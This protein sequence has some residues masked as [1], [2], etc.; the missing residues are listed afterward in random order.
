MMNL[1]K[2]IQ[3]LVERFLGIRIS[4]YPFEV[5]QIIPNKKREDAWFSYHAIFQSII[6][7]YQVDLVLDVG[8]NKGQFVREL[9]GFYPGTV[10]SFEPVPRTFAALQ[11]ARPQDNN[12]FKLNYALGSKSE[13]QYINT[14]KKDELNS[15]LETNDNFVTRFGPAAAISQKEPIKVRR[16][17]DVLDEIPFDINNRKILLKMD[18]QGYDLEVFHGARKILGNIVAL[19]SEISQLPVYQHTPRWTDTVNEYEKAGF[20]LAGLYPASRDG[21]RYIICDC[22]MVKRPDPPAVK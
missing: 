6:E 12:W 14:F 19:Q 10:V 16:L 13:D 17:D 18:T 11:M 4:G 22:L 15:L 20:H 2:K 3:R 1:L 8:A 5:M 21:L 7:K 9:R